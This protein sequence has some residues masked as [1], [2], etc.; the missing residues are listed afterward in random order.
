MS[1][2]ILSGDRTQ[3]RLNLGNTAIDRHRLVVVIFGSFAHQRTFMGIERGGLDE[4][5]GELINA[6]RVTCETKP[7]GLHE[8]LYITANRRYDRNSMKQTRLQLRRDCS[9]EYLQVLQGD[10]LKI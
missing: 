1:I 7:I 5:F 8:I 10:D 3:D 4:G 6:F 2:R 9:V